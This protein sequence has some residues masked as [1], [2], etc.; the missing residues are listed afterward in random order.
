[1]HEK[2]I[3]AV[4]RVEF[5]SDR[6]SYI[7]LR[8]HWCHII[9]LNVHDPTK[10]KT[11]DVKDSFYEEFECVFDKFPKHKLCSHFILSEHLMEPKGLLPNSQELSVWSYPE[12]D[13]S[14]PH[15]PMPPLEVYE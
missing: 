15:H 12:P 1:V 3:S 7:I 5:V 14:S 8:G 2:L 6:M 10:H 13:Q 9:L 11:N 4:K